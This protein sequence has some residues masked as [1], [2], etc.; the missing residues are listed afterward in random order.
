MTSKQPHIG[1]LV[2]LTEPA[3]EV[4]LNFFFDDFRIMPWPDGQ[5]LQKFRWQKQKLI[6]STFVIAE[7]EEEKSTFGYTKYSL[8]LFFSD[9]TQNIKI[10]GP[11]INSDSIKRIL[12]ALK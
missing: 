3:K 2:K 11:L 12:K 8:I 4:Y 9:L 6:N 1:Q 7:I 10:F 5:N